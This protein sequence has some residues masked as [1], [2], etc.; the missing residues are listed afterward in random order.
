[1]EING[2]LTLEKD[3]LSK[4]EYQMSSALKNQE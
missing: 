1:M 4:N 3:K 2:K